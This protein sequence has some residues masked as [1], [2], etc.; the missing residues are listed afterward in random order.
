[1]ELLH[2]VL[3]NA[4][5]TETKN[6]AFFVCGQLHVIQYKYVLSPL[7][8]ANKTQC[9]PLQKV[10]MRVITKAIEKLDQH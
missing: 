2:L 1:M 8:M 7:S 5:L 6:E 4:S 10:M 3:N 9:R